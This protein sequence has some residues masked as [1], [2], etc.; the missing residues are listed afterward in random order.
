MFSRNPYPKPH[1]VSIASRML[2]GQVAGAQAK[3]LRSS[4]LIEGSLAL[5]SKRVQVL[6][7]PRPLKHAY[8]L[9]LVSW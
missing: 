4:L 8:Q 1:K 2:R 5:C 3:G 9:P 7:V 6:Q